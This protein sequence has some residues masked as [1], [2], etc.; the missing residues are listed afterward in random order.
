MLRHYAK[1]ER[2]GMRSEAMG[3]VPG[4]RLLNAVR[5]SLLRMGGRLPGML[6]EGGH[7]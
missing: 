4:G 5:M 2:A 1:F 6:R 7:R 3:A